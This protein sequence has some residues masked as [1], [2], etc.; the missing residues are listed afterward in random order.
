M[1]TSP[2]LLKGKVAALTGG[3]TGIGRAITIGLLEHGCHVGINYLGGPSDE[4]LLLKLRAD[5]PNN[6]T[7]FIAVAGDISNPATGNQLVE[8]VVAR[9]SRLNVFVSNAGICQFAEFLECVTSRL[10]L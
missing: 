8:K 2:Q 1:D 9:W 10:E 6:G 5:L 7:E 3:L 4:N